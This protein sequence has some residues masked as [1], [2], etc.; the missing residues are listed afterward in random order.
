MRHKV[1][2]WLE[3]HHELGYQIQKVIKQGRHNSHSFFDRNEF[4]MSKVI[5]PESRM[6][7]ARCWTVGEMGRWWSKGTDFQ[8]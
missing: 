2:K 6:V 5:E 8:L 4:G 3:V 1:T 7:V